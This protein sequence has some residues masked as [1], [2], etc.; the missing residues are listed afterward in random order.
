MKDVVSSLLSPK[1]DPKVPKLIPVPTPVSDAGLCWAAG[2]AQN[3]EP[4]AEKQK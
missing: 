3:Q 4:T 1:V 2:A